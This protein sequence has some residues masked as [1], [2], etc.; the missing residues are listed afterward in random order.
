MTARINYVFFPV[1]SP[2]LLY[3][4]TQRLSVTSAIGVVLSP[5][6]YTISVSLNHLSLIYG[7]RTVVLILLQSYLESLM[8]TLW[9]SLKC[10][11]VD[12]CHKKSDAVPRCPF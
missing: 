12:V 4:P 11:V 5:Y 6:C 3:T 2:A 7:P 8:P 1:G 10:I 9:A